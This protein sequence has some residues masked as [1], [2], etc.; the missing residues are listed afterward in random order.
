MSGSKNIISK[1]KQSFRINEELFMYLEDFDRAENLPFRYPDLLRFN[2]TV[3]LLD[4]AGK[5][6][7]WETVFYP[8]GENEE[9]NHRLIRTYAMMKVEGNITLMEHLYVDRIDFCPFGNSKPF[10]IRIKNQYN[11]NYDYYYVK[12]ADASRVYGLEFED[13]LSPNRINYIV[14][15]DTLVEEH[16]IG[17]PGDQFVQYNLNIPGIN[18]TRLAKEF[19]KFNE[20][21]FVRLLG[22]MRS[23][24]FVIDMTADFDDTQFRFRAI[25]FDQQS[26]EGRKSI[27][28]PQ[29][30][31]ENNPYV[32]LCIK[33]INKETVRQYQLEERSLMA[34][35][36]K[37]ARFRLASLLEVM[38]NDTVSLKDKV[39]QLKTE[40]AEHYKKDSFLKC[41][42]MGEIMRVS[43]NLL[44]ETSV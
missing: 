14:D 38:Q 24:N 7:L 15:A 13:L 43:L 32:D 11:D 4:K 27:Y 1:K 41:K 36:I 34:R 29:F 23:Y 17:I 5:D 9:L 33:Y 21:C 3:P 20:R 19:I 26:Y 2:Y 12:L 40:L 31:K 30:F 44:L 22:D 39:D 28:L 37:I 10:R 6:T 42:N 18:H 8:P 35:R 25:D 16:I